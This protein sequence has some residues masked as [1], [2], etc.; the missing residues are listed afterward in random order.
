M[1]AAGRARRALVPELPDCSRPSGQFARRRA[2]RGHPS[3]TRRR[4]SARRPRPTAAPAATGS[5]TRRARRAAGRPRRG[6]RAA[7]GGRRRPARR[8]RGR[9]RRRPGSADRLCTTNTVEPCQS[10]RRAKSA[11]GSFSISVLTPQPSSGVSRRS[12]ASRRMKRSSESGVRSLLGDGAPLHRRAHAHAALEREVLDHADL[13]A[14]EHHRRAGQREQQRPRHAQPRAVAAEH[15]GGAAADPVPV[16]AHV[17]L[18]REGGEDLVAL[19]RLELVERQLV[20]V[21]Q[22]GRPARVVG[23]HRQPA[24][25]VLQGRR[26]AAGERRATGA[27]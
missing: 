22:E 9:A 8:R 12:W 26:V 3:S 13:V 19:G 2:A 16:D 6:A 23:R 18:G 10:E 25:Q 1:A 20:V 4:A 24:D 11:V 15:R 14:V 21:A 7:P 5:R 17:L 27:G